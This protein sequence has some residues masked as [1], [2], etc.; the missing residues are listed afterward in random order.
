MTAYQG[1]EIFLY[2]IAVATHQQR[3]G[4]G[5][6]LID[7][8][9]SEAAA[10]GIQ[11]IFVAADDQDTGALDFYRAIGGSPTRVTFFELPAASPSKT[12]GT[13]NLI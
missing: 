13:V 3:R 10:R 1:A 7:A 5:R 4:F 2:D 6:Q 12:W 8:L 11:T 9:R